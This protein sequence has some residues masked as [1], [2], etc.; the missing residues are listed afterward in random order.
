MNLT[1]TINQLFRKARS[2]L[3]M[4]SLVLIV[5]AGYAQAED[6]FQTDS[7]D[8]AETA[9]D[10]SSEPLSNPLEVGV[11]LGVNGDNDYKLAPGDRLR[12]IVLGHG[13]LSI[14]AQVS[15]DNSI[16]YPYL[17]ELVIGGLTRDEVESLVYNALKGPYLVEPTVSVTILSYR[18]FY[19]LGEVTRAGAYPYTPGLTLRRAILDAGNFKP[20]AN[21]NRIYLINELEEDQEERRIDQSHQIKPGDIITVRASFF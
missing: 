16:I 20:T 12:I 1:D 2:C 10:I 4:L 8:P 7:L 15:D 9:A 3:V 14:E 21:K 17:G 5:P 19:L 13:D 18:Q 11:N 6:Q